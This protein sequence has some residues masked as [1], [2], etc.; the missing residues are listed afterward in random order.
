MMS[1]SRLRT[2]FSASCPSILDK[3]TRFAHTPAACNAPAGRLRCRQS[4]RRCGRSPRHNNP[5]TLPR[6]HARSTP[7][8]R[9][10]C[11]SISV[12]TR[13][14]ACAMHLARKSPLGIGAVFLIA[15]RCFWICSSVSALHSRPL[16]G[17][18][19]HL[20]LQKLRAERFDLLLDDWPRVIGRDFRA[21]R[22]AV[23][24]AC[25]PATPTR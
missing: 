10:S 4:S 13:I 2:N 14:G 11:V 16:S 12:V 22:F 5:S 7:R 24:M 6:F 20:D 21:E 15:S 1:S 19:R 23:A 17:R 25:K 8:S 18:F 3:P 9:V